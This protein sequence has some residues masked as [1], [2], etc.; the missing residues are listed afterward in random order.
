MSEALGDKLR[1]AREE[2]GMT[3]E[4][5]AAV[6]KLNAQFIEALE[7][8][9]WDLLPGQVY[10]K[11][12]VKACA[13][14]LHLNLKELYG[15]IDGQE[16][17]KPAAAESQPEV[18]VRGKRLDY[19]IP[20]VIIIALIVIAV[21]YYTVK[22][23]QDGIFSSEVSEIVP[24]ERVV[25][26][27]EAKWDRPWQ[28]PALWETGG[29]RHRLHL[30]ASDTVWVCVL[31]DGDTTFTGFLNPG[32]VRTVTTSG[33]LQV[34]LGRND[35]IIGFFDGTRIEGMGTGPIGPR[36]FRL[37]RVNERSDIEH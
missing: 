2:K 34:S 24:A 17:E 35:C 1:Q 30:E 5:L 31:I 18:P 13:E 20:V 4:Q 16:T 6:T 8:G 36:S 29:D 9:R 23:R 10:L 26:R 25:P 19:R 7:R 22:S 21:I 12:F 11:P 32:A 27:K 28:R 3:I 37:G 33:N 14:A 15:L